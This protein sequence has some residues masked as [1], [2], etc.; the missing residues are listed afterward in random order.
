MLFFIFYL[1]LSL[2]YSFSGWSQISLGTH[3]PGAKVYIYMYVI[4]MLNKKFFNTNNIRAVSTYSH[5]GW[6]VLTT[7]LEM[8]Q[9]V[10]KD[11][12]IPQ[13]SGYRSVCK[14]H[15]QKDIQKLKA[16]LGLSLL[17]HPA[18]LVVHVHQHPLGFLKLE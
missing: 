4:C 10:F 17:W 12:N 16:I 18:I 6:P 14:L 9:A 3:R 2:D 13:S 5:M 8:R 15:Q 11:I 7:A 1:F